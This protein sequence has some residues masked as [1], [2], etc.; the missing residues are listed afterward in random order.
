ML[1]CPWNSPGKNTGVG[2]HSFLQGIFPTH[3]LNPVLLHGGQILYCVRF[4]L[5]AALIFAILCYLNSTHVHPSPQRVNSCLS[6]LFQGIFMIDVAEIWNSSS[7]R[8]KT[9]SLLIKVGEK[10]LCLL[11]LQSPMK[12]SGVENSFLEFV[13]ILSCISHFHILHLGET[14]T[15]GIYAHLCTQGHFRS[16]FSPRCLIHCLC[17]GSEIPIHFTT[18]K[19][20]WRWVWNQKPHV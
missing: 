8:G 9:K 12:D 1:L 18:V 19:W 3:G 2:S 11:G 4:T 14:D 7:K 5:K 13:W 10:W 6:F 16:L 17:K 20:Q 15:T